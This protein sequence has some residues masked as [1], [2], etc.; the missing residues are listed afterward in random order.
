MMA[1]QCA[2]EIDDNPLWNFAL[3]FYANK[4]VQSLLLTLQNDHQQDTLLIL[5]ALWLSQSGQNWYLNEQQLAPYFQW[6]QDVIQPLRNVRKSIPKEGVSVSILAL[7]QQIQNDEIRAEQLGLLQLLK[8]HPSFAIE[9]RLSS[10][11]L[12]LSNLK[13]QA[14]INSDITNI[15]KEAMRPLFL[16]LAQ[17]LMNAD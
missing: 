6:R 5:T 16:Q 17:R 2:T 7:R 15:K 13:T 11:A 8:L 3:H 14:L 4:D 9:E 1:A 10:Q 12:I